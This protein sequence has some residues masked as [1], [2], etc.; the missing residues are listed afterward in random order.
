M[1]Q[2]KLRRSTKHSQIDL[3]NT[4]S[5]IQALLQTTGAGIYISQQGKF[6]YVSPL[7]EQLSGY[8]KNELLGICSLDLIYPDDR[9]TVRT[10]AIENLKHPSNNS[11]YEFRIIS[12][13][14]TPIWVMERV[15]SIEY[16]EERAVMGSFMDITEK[17]RIEEAL[18]HSEERF[19]TILE[20][21]QDAYF[22]LDLAGNFTYVN[23]T[24]SNSMGY[25]REE[26]MG[27]NFRLTTP[28]DE[29]K[30]LFL[31]FNE[32][33]RTE[34]PNKAFS[35]TFLQ[36]D[37][38]ILYAESSIDLC[39]NEK[40]EIVG[41]RCVSRDITERRKLEEELSRSEQRFRTIIERMQDGY[42]EVDLRG[43][44]TFANFSMTNTIGY[45]IPE[46]IGKNY[47][48]FIPK[49]DIQRVFYAYNEVYRLG[50]P[51]KGLSHKF[52]R[53]D[54]TIIFL[55]ST[56]DL[57]TNEAGEVIGFKTVSRD[58]SERK[59]LE[60]ALMQS[61][62]RYRT[63]LEEME[64][65][66][67]EVDLAGNFT[68]VNDATCRYTGY[69]R[70]ELIGMNY[71]TV[72]HKDDIALIYRFYNHTYRTGE[73]NKGFSHR[74]VRK[75]GSICFVEAAVSLIK[76]KQGEA[77]GFRCVSRDVT[78]R[79]LLEEELARSE[80]KYRTIL[81]QMQDAY[82]EIDADGNFLFTNE[83]TCQ[84]MGIPFDKLIE[85]NYNDLI[86]DEERPIVNEAFSRVFATG[87]PNRAF[88]HRVILA[89]GN[90]VFAEVSISPLKDKQ[91]KTIG[92]R[93]VA[94]DVTERKQMEQL[95][96]DMATHDFLTELPNRVLLIDRFEVAL[97]QALRKDY[98]L[99]I[100]SLDLDRFKEVN[101]T[102]G[103]NVGDEVL[104]RVANKLALTVRSSD[105]V[106]R[107]GGD[108]FLLLLQ[109]I[110]D[111]E[112]ATT[113]ADKIIHSFKE[114]ITVEGHGFYLTASMG[115]AI[116]PD[117]GNDLE[118]LMKKS[119]ASMYYSKRHGGNQYKVYS[120]SDRVE[121]S[122]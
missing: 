114:P 109:E 83:A 91:G 44:Y 65:A 99:A 49:E 116:C 74:M 113:I 11:P 89:T 122:R 51:N 100:M 25:S 9:V 55:E 10:R 61:E 70:D 115:I 23:F 79:K 38:G 24:A 78:S 46:L 18:S 52:R 106:G 68:F 102:M 105:T 67:Y 13:S 80:E 43:N 86:P 92:F 5:L 8:P 1:T 35:H 54:G 98:K 103:H 31:A 45:S 29:H 101:D 117:D 84:S 37:G 16:S 59:L 120:S 17:K 121:F 6:V 63:I 56:I 42:Y 62:E 96:A 69:T 15:T 28:T 4:P 66:Y 32:V 58:I 53:K 27:K 107:L 41:F 57:Q 71:R 112:D 110:H 7:V 12:K 36:K 60:E 39:R 50:I 2:S 77:V 94:R 47:R 73:P 76:N 93:C 75:D 20:G 82:Y 111:L 72:A 3:E 21:M 97:A 119:D 87:I 85:T 14:G 33:Y 48:L 30:T 34:A 88:A 104:K 22:E 81:E 108:E 90:I 26:L 118:T 64:D 19:R 95:L 40:G